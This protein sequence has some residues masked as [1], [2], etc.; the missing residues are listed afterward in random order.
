MLVPF[1][2]PNTATLTSLTV[3]SNTATGNGGGL[4]VDAPAGGGRVRIN[5]SII[6][7]NTATGQGLDVFAVAFPVN[8][9]IV[10]QGYNF[11]GVF[12]GSTGWNAFDVG[13]GTAGAG[14]PA[15]GALEDNGGKTMTITV[16]I[17][18]TAVYRVGNP[19][20]SGTKDQR[21]LTRAADKV[22]IGAYDP[23]AA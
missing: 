15:L 17:T 1:S 21:G 13:F 10:S 14:N 7:G 23:D 19:A 12:A 9:S 4:W 3:Y 5:N 6:A 16:P 8:P 18:N 2:F 11:I 22:T 20:L